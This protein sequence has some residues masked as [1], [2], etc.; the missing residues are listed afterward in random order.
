MPE[1]VRRHAFPQLQSIGVP[2]D[3]A[4][5]R[6]VGDDQ[7]GG[8]QLA[9]GQ[10]ATD[11]R[12]DPGVRR[13]GDDAEGMTRP[14]E[15]V[16]VELEHRDASSIDAIAEHPGPARM[17]LDRQ[18]PAARPCERQGQRAVAGSEVDDDV[19]GSDGSLGDHTIGPLRPER[20]PSPGRRGP[21]PR[22]SRGHGGP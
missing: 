13:V 12:V 19:T 6:T 14:A 5:R 10:Q 15:G 8:S 16:Q 22:L 1:C 11:Q 9:H 20:M 7:V 2:P 3:Q 18:D 17:K 21:T 4:S